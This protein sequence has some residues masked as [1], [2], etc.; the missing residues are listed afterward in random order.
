MAAPEDHAVTQA[1]RKMTT[2]DNS[3]VSGPQA[4]THTISDSD[5]GSDGELLGFEPI[6]KA[7]KKAAKCRAQTPQQHHMSMQHMAM[8]QYPWWNPA[9]QLPHTQTMPFPQAPWPVMPQMMWQMP[10]A[11][12]AQTEHSEDESQSDDEDGTSS[13]SLSLPDIS[14]M[15]STQQPVVAGG[16]S[17]DKHL[18]LAT[19]ED[20]VGPEIHPEVAK[21]ITKIW[22]KDQK[23]HI[24]ELFAEAPRPVNV[25]CLHKVDLDDEILSALTKRPNVKDLDFALRGIHHTMV[26]AATMVTNLLQDLHVTDKPVCRQQLGDKAIAALRILSY[27]TQNT[28]SLRKQQIRPVLLPEVRS[29]LC[30][31][32][33][34]LADINKSHMLFGGDVPN[35]VKKGNIDTTL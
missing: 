21:L 14:P 2:K 25:P 32:N 28:H 4:S 3:S 12:P 20:D 6:T 19:A 15:S 8:A 29:K 31:K 18:E 24:K 1:E 7:S 26:R 35:Q 11:G 34:S 10:G 27:G 16:L 22:D 9:M 33:A 5:Q 17:L 30:T 23:G 13:Y